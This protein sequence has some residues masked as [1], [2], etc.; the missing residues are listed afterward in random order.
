MNSRGYLCRP[1]S[2]EILTEQEL[3][4]GL[5]NTI[6]RGQ[7]SDGRETLA[8]DIVIG[9]HT[10][11]LLFTIHTNTWMDAPTSHA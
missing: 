4:V 9:H 7:L 10:F 3:L 8:I 1:E 2:N 6:L 5:V 11:Q